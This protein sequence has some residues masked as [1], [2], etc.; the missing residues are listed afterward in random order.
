MKNWFSY[1]IEHFNTLELNVTFYRFPQLSVFQNWYDKSSPDFR[2]AVKAPRLITHYK[3]FNDCQRLLDNFYSTLRR[4]PKRKMWLLSLSSFRR[5][6]IIR[7]KGWKKLSAV[8][9]LISGTS[10]SSDMKAGGRSMFSGNCHVQKISF[11]G[12]SHPDLPSSVVQ[13]SPLFYYR[14][15]GENQLYASRYTEEQLQKFAA[16]VA[17]K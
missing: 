13:N 12:M 4:G 8:W 6:T 1:Y 2:F 14:F 10:W 11:C 16:E 17:A 9:I 5:P 3:K 15:H 7:K